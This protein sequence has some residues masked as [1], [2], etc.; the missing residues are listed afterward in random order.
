MTKVALVHPNIYASKNDVLLASF[1][2]DV[3]VIPYNVEM[4]KETLLATI[5][6]EGASH[7]AFLYHFPGYAR[8]P[9]FDIVNEETASATSKYGFISDA[10]IDIF[11]TLKAIRPLTVDILSCSL[12]DIKYK[13]EIATIETDLNIDIRYSTDK[14]GNGADGSN[15]TMESELPALV[16]VR[17]LYFTDA[18]LQWS[19]VLS[20]DISAAIKAGGA[21]AQYISW[22]SATKTFTLLKNINWVEFASTTGID[23]TDWIAINFDETFDGNNKTIDMNVMG[24]WQGLF[25]AINDTNNAFVR[26]TVRN[27]KMINGAGV[28]PFSGYI[29][30]G[31]QRFFNIDNCSVTGNIL[32][33]GAGGISGFRSGYL[34]GICSITNCH[35]IGNVS[36]GSAGGIVGLFAAQAGPGKAAAPGWGTL[37]IDNCYHHGD[38]PGA[39]S[40]GICGSEASLT[41]GRVY[42]NNCNNIGVVSGFAAGGIVG[43]FAGNVNGLVQISKCYNTS[44]VTGQNAGG[45]IGQN[46]GVNDGKVDVID[47]YNTGAIGNLSGG[48]FGSHASN[49]YNAGS[50]GEANATNCYNSGVVTGNGGGILGNSARMEGAGTCTVTNCVSNGTLVSPV[51]GPV[52]VT[53]SSTDISTINNARPAS[54]SGSVWSTGLAVPVTVSG[55]VQNNALPI[56]NVFKA[57]PFALNVYKFATD[58]AVFIITGISVIV[59]FDVNTDTSGAI[60]VFSQTA[61]NVNNMVLAT[62]ALPKSVLYNGPG[63]GLIKFQG[64]DNNIVAVLDSGFTTS[65]TTIRDALHLV[66]RSALNAMNAAPYNTLVGGVRKYT[67]AA[68]YI[69]PSFGALALGAYAHYLFGHVQATAAID[70]DTIF[71]EKMN[72]IEEGTARIPNGLAN[73]I[74]TLNESKSLAIAKQ[75]IGQDVSRAINVDNDINTPSTWQTLE[76]RTGDSVFF[77]VVLKTPQVTR[78]ENAPY[79]SSEINAVNYV[80]TTYYVKCILE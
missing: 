3:K 2:A 1:A 25:V 15:W 55:V 7:I 36:G 73:Q 56:L 44:P 12:S 16:N 35:H 29:M 60:N 21:F 67:D 62:T 74:K 18:V 6:N 59:N 68:H 77:A 46:A 53:N 70:N 26:S 48:I 65:E 27:L 33:S 43:S 42:I 47:C 30:R 61:P 5:G 71:I 9:F 38:I 14:T 64:V 63:N 28:E 20:G 72:G 23:D 79:V 54:W 41:G 80:E 40:G 76:F 24:L 57:A 17:D 22:N 4:T 69:L 13:E 52:T 78:V 10:V 8:L 50:V 11:T 34:H 45:I 31:M 32:T 51:Q 39:R 66:I 19:G 49:T 75:V 37:T 58:N